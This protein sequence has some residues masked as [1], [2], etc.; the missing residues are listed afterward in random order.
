VSDDESEVDCVKLQ[1]QFD[2]ERLHVPDIPSELFMLVWRELHRLVL[3]VTVEPARSEI[4]VD[5]NDRVL[6]T[7]VFVL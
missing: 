4:H 3:T 6:V 2:P 7:T 5:D 1:L